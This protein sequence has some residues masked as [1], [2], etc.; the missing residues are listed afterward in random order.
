MSHALLLAV[1]IGIVAGL[2]SLTAPALVAWAV[3]LGWLDL[4]GSPVSWIGS[5]AAV[6]VFSLLAIVE[7]IGDVLPQTPPR[8]SL[9]GL[10]ARIVAGGATGLCV[11]AAAQ[12]RP[13]IMGIVYGVIGA[14]IGTYGGYHIRRGLVNGLKVKDILVAIPEDIVAIALGYWIVR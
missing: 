8:T 12:G 1:G 6:W 9:M 13:P 2:R 7:L 5:T 14:L 3:H 10:S 11:Y 4:H